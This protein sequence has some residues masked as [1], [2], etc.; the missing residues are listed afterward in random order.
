MRSVNRLIVFISLC[1]AL[2]IGCD[3]SKVTMKPDLDSPKDETSLKI[4][5][6]PERNIFR[7]LEHYQPLANYLAKN[8]GNKVELKILTRYGNI[9]DNFVS[10]DLDAAFFGSFT[11]TLAHAKLGVDV[12]ARPE[13]PSGI[14]TYHGLVFVRKDSG[15][16][17]FKDING[18]VFAFVD[19]ATTAGF[20]FP[21][22]LFK[23]NG[24]ADYKEFLKETYFTGTHEDAIYDVLNKKADIGAAKNTIFYALAAEDK[25]L[26]DELLIIEKSLDVPENGIAVSKDLDGRIKDQLKDLLLNMHNDPEGKKILKDFGARI[27][28]ET[29]DNDYSNVNTL[30]KEIGLNLKTYDYIN[31]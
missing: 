5:L 12:I 3:D 17:S 20:I 19:K 9:I 15:I 18:K 4:G 21:L 7:Q 6:I 16:K 23:R 14:S 26:L 29:T 24:I 10:A 13:Y 2:M 11:Y 28:I 22:A 30:A 8:L 25:R 27:F 1:F 31:E